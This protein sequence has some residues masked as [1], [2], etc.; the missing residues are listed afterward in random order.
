M[1]SQTVKKFL[2]ENKWKY[3]QKIDEEGYA[4]YNLVMKINSKI[5]HLLL[6]HDFE[7]EYFAVTAVNNKKISTKYRNF[8]M[9]IFNNLAQQQIPVTHI[10]T[11]HGMVATKYNY[12]V[13]DEKLSFKRINYMI[14]KSLLDVQQL[15]SELK[16][17]IKHNKKKFKHDKTSQNSS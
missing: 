13:L 8:V 11:E 2:D 14:D 12:E 9:Q 15:Y 7:E 6:E 16:K 1:I 17:A 3:E 4:Y 5:F 10:F